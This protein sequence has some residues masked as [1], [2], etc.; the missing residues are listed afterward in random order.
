MRL[1]GRTPPASVDGQSLVPLLHG[2]VPANWRDAVL[3]EH[4]HPESATGDP[5]HQAPPSGNPPSYEALRSADWL[6]VEYA[7]GDREFYDLE[8]DP[9][10]LDNR[11]ERLDPHSRRML[12]A[13]LT[14]LENCRG[15][16]CR[17]AA[18]P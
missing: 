4:H 6:Y 18:A 8:S 3:I 14:L 17:A 10:E 1:A 7:T 15:K 5:D 2:S 11:Y 9:A 13:R 12:H 16:G